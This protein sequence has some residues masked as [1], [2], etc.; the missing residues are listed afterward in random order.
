MKTLTF[1]RDQVIFQ[2][3]TYGNTMYDIVSG[4]VGVYMNYKTG[5]EKQLAEMGNSE[6]FGEMGMI[7]VYPRSATAVALEDGTVLAEITE[8]ELSQY[9]KD[10]PEKILK[11]LRLLSQRIR[12]TDKKYLDVCRTV[13]ESNLEKKESV[14]KDAL[15]NAEL[16]MIC[17]EYNRFNSLWLN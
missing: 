1:D 13:Y 12:E 8:A 16:E 11:L 4:K 2:E 9:F 3:G 17:R 14:P 7:E 15:I 6:V 10:K 5:E